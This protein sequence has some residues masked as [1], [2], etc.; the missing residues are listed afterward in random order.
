[1]LT[2][3]VSLLSKAHVAQKPR[4][5][6]LEV[7]TMPE[8]KKGFGLLPKQWVVERS[9]VTLSLWFKMYHTL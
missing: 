5:M 3:N 7:V 4:H 1:M 9:K 6:H 2:A 8:A